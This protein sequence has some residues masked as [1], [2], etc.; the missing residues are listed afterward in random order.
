MSVNPLEHIHPACTEGFSEKHT[1]NYDAARPTYTEKVMD[2]IMRNTVHRNSVMK[3]T[4]L[5]LNPPKYTFMEIGAGTGLFT[6]ALIDAI[7]R[8][9]DESFYEFRY[10]V[11]V[12]EPVEG[13]ITKFNEMIEK[14]DKTQEPKEE[15]KGSTKDNKKMKESKQ[16][17]ENDEDENDDE[18][19]EFEE[20]D[21]EDEEDEEMEEESDQQEGEDFEDDDDVE[22]DEVADLEPYFGKRADKVKVIHASAEKIPVEDNSVHCVFAAQAFHW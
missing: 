4:D 18:D 2:E 3:Q 1:D 5:T 19:Y 15:E 17:D 22:Y 12:I 10:E 14:V 9:M 8:Y 7:E 13:M 21:E 6:R 16:D 11:I 20:E